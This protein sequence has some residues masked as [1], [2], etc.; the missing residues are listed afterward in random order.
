MKIKKNYLFIGSRGKRKPICIIFIS[1]LFYVAI[2]TIDL[3]N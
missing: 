1:Q 3:F 2:T